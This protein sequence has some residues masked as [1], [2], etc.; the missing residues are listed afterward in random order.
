SSK[1]ALREQAGLTDSRQKSSDFV[2]SADRESLGRCFVSAIIKKPGST[3]TAA[4]FK[5]VLSQVQ[6]GFAYKLLSAL[7]AGV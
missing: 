5:S 1:S 2:H 4:D 6:P 3:L 7:C